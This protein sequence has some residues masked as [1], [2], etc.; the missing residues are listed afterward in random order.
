MGQGLT[1]RRF[2]ATGGA[3]LAALY[4]AGGGRTGAGR[5]GELHAAGAVGARR[6]PRRPL[7]DPAHLRRHPAR[8]V[9]APGLQRRARPAVA[10]RPVA[11]ARAR[12]A[13]GGVRARLRR[14]GPRRAAVP[15]PRRHRARVRRLRRRRGGRSPTAFA[16][17]RQRLRRPDRARHRAAAAGVRGARLPARAL[18]GRGRRAD[19]QPRARLQPRRQV[20]RALVLR[21]HGREAEELRRSSSRRWRYEIPDGLDLDD[22]PDDVLDVYDLAIAPVEFAAPGGGRRAPRGRQGSNNWTSPAG[23]PRPAARSSPTTRT[24]PRACRRCATWR[25]SPRPG[26]T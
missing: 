23:A 25:T 26:S 24:A 15:L 14:A 3:A 16:D 6:D 17:G 12:P 8:R 9:P 21:D 19:P 5:A 4:A 2:V 10:D 18:G 13:V 20:A 22:I 11:P 1:R 7:G